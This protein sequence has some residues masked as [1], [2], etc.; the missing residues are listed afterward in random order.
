MVWLGRFI[1]YLIGTNQ[2]IQTEGLKLK[3]YEVISAKQLVL[4]LGVA[5]YDT[6]TS[7]Q[8]CSI[9]EE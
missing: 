8:Q 5:V 4:L 1:G 7:I 2:Q 3:R 6:A 9:S